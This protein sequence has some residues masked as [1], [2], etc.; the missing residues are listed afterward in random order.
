[1]S[2]DK[3]LDSTVS[4]VFNSNSLYYEM[5]AAWHGRQDGPALES[6]VKQI[7][8]A[9]CLPDS[10][11]LE[12]G[13]GSGSITNWF[14]ARHT[15]VRFVGV[16][17]SSIGVQM[18]REGAPTNAQYHVADLKQLPFADK[19]FTFIFSQSVIEHVVGWEDA[20]AELH[21]VLI[22]GGELLIRVGNG[23]SGFHG[24]H[25]GSHLRAVLNYLLRRN[26]VEVQ[27][28]SFQLRSGDWSQH[29]TNFDVQEI[30]SDVLLKVLRRL[31]FSIS[32]FTTGTEKWRGSGN[33]KAE[34]V[35]YLPFWPFNHLGST[36]IVLAKK[37]TR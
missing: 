37:R 10:H 14:A 12:G 36:S 28:P 13:S 11:V 35:S 26:R 23:G 32:Y 22:D 20:L 8:K 21:R 34:L 30:P 1:M 24:Q 9:H 31:R 29:V 6:E 25:A 19:T 7:I 2:Y 15:D 18:A 5:M 4:E 33:W 16:D 3:K 27:T 17:I